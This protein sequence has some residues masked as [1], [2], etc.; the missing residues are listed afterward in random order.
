VKKIKKFIVLYHSPKEAVD[1]MSSSSPE[2]MKKGM[3]PWVEWAKKCGE[4]LVDLGTP[5]GNG[6]RVEKGGNTASSSDVNGYSILQAENMDEAV[7]LLQ[8]HPHL[9]WAEGCSIEVFEA[10]P[11]PG[12]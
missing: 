8:N 4:R 7:S 1:A 10:M 2:D 5:L 3:E 9:G 12:M 6:Q 11:L